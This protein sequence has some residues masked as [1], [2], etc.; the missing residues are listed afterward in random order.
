MKRD[1]AD[2]TSEEGPDALRE[3]F[4]R[5]IKERQNKA[6]K[7]N[8][9]PANRLIKSSA[10]FVD[11]FVPP[12]YLLE[13]VLQRRFCY[14]FTAKTNTGKTGIM[15][16]LAAHVALGRSIGDRE[17]ERGR[18]LFLSGENPDD[19]RMRWIAMAQQMDFDIKGIDVYFVPGTFK[20]S[21]MKARIHAEIEALGEVAFVI[22]DTSAA[23]FEGEDENDNKQ[24]GGHARLLR[25]LTELPGGPCVLAACHPTKNAADD[26][27]QPRGGGS[28]IAEMDGN[29]TAKCDD[30]AV[31]VHWQ[32]KFRGPDFAPLCFQMR[33]VTHERLKD[34]K[35]RLLPTVVACP[36][37]DAAQ[38][39]M[40]T[41]ARSREDALLKVL[42][43]NPTASQADLAN[44]LGWKMRD[45]RPYKVRVSR[46]LDALKKAKLITKDRGGFALTPRGKK[47]LDEQR[48]KA[49]ENADAN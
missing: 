46:A 16:L 45:G 6:R 15:L 48:G 20:I 5:S 8:G 19:V 35:G 40:A 33:A 26:N 34:R 10:E 11:G 43:A 39:E 14:S 21:E 38:R 41:A 13:G 44:L 28:Y 31:E 23:Y 25:S 27:L 12:D 30:G 42:A 37:S 24:A 18:V 47:I 17:V 32:G 4:D 29:L 7:F 3:A 36:L 2:I 22:I 49:A 9:V 1:A